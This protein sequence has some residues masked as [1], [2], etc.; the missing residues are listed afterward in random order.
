MQRCENDKKF[1]TQKMWVGVT[2][3]IGNVEYLFWI[4]EWILIGVLKKKK[5]YLI[6]SFDL[7]WQS[8]RIGWL[9]SAYHTGR[10]DMFTI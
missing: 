3:D 10:L 6:Y 8:D 5:I 1:F 9:L 4:F 2:V 7:P